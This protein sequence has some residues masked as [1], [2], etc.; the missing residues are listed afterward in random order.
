MWGVRGSKGGSG[1]KGGEM[2][3]TM[4]GHMKKTK[5]LKKDKNVDVWSELKLKDQGV[6]TTKFWR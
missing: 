6:K 1:G 4:Y 2:T 3:Q 5:I